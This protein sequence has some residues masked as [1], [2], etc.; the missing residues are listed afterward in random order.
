MPVE[1]E[2]KK[3][4]YAVLLLILPVFLFGCNEGKEEGD[5]PETPVNVYITE[6]NPV[7]GAKTTFR[8]GEKIPFS[9]H[10]KD[11]SKLEEITISV[12]GKIFLHSKEQKSD[13]AVEIP[14]DSVGVG[15]QRITADSKVSGNQYGEHLS[16]TA[17]ILSDTE[18]GI[19]TYKVI[20][21]YPHDTEAYTQGLYLDNGNLYEGTGQNGKSQLRLWDFKQNK[22]LQSVNLDARYFGEGIAP[23]KDR[24]YQLTW[25]GRVCFVYDK[26]TLKQIQQFNYPTEGWGLTFDGKYLVMSDGTQYLYFYDPETFRQVKKI[27][28]ADNTGIAERLN[29]LEYINGEIW[30]NVYTT[31]WVVA[32]DPAT[33]KITKKIDFSNILTPEEELQ[34]NLDV[35]N[36]IAYDSAAGKLYITGKNWP[37]LYEVQVIE[38]VKG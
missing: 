30:A 3:T 20:R 8:L 2:K 19:Y 25:R 33:G 18:P 13:F 15:Q 7:A 35:L 12:N 21:K 37:G 28:V 31:D 17:Y 9:V 34:P 11:P 26:K 16:S 14:A 1:K 4:W 32:I 36:G 24:I 5:D 23:Y 29:E 10:V 27:Q 6:I 22:I 38:K